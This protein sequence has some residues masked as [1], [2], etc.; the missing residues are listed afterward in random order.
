MRPV[1]CTV[2]A[3]MVDELYTDEVQINWLHYLINELF[4][5]VQELQEKGTTFHYSWLLI[6]ISF[7]GWEELANCQ[8]VYFP[9]HC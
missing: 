9:L 3:V 6:L 2:G 8:G 1:Q 5:D 4:I 7:V